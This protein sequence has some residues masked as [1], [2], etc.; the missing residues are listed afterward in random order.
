MIVTTFLWHRV[1]NIKYFSFNGSYEFQ[2]YIT[3][4][5]ITARATEAVVRRCSIKKMFLKISQNSQEP[6]VAAS[7][8]MNIWIKCIPFINNTWKKNS[9]WRIQFNK[10]IS[11]KSSGTYENCLFVE[12]KYKYVSQLKETY[13]AKAIASSILFGEDTTQDSC[14]NLSLKEL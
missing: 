8:A 10:E 1:T 4:Y 11:G 6:L 2:Q 7:G 3:K 13:R 5:V 9:F 14:Y 12:V